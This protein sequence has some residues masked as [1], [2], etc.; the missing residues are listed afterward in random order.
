M[1]NKKGFTLVE[2]LVAATIIGFLAVFATAQYRNSVAEARWT[3]AKSQTDQLAAALQRWY[4]DYPTTGIING[5]EMANKAA[6]EQCQIFIGQ[7]NGVSITQLIACGFLE[8]SDW[9]SPYFRYYSCNQPTTAGQ[10]P[11]CAAN[12]RACMAA[13]TT[14]KL[15]ASYKT[16]KYCVDFSGVG[17]EL[18]KTTNY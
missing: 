2:L 18:T 15:P 10:W 9:S 3:R 4:M 17:Q 5:G 1:M 8:N 13:R 14:A 12:Y 11:E 7:Q 6:N 16:K